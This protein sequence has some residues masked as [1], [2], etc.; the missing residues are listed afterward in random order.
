MSRIPITRKQATELVKSLPVNRSVAASAA[1]AGG[2]AVARRLTPSALRAPTVPGGVEPLPVES[3]VGLTYTTDG[4]RSYPA[5]AA[6]GLLVAG[7]VKPAVV[8][9][10]TPTVKGT[11][12]LDD[13]EGA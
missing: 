7:V 2:T 8:L 13:V 1:R 3:K 4:A 9:F 5:R 6:R 10:A 11:D 12:R